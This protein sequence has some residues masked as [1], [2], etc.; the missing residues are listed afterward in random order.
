MNKIVDNRIQVLKQPSQ[1]EHPEKEGQCL[2]FSLELAAASSL[3]VSFSAL[4]QDT[5]TDNSSR[6]VY[7]RAEDL[8]CG[9]H[10]HADQ[11]RTDTLKNRLDRSSRCPGV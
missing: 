11:T 3:Y 10:Y 1:D 2:E 8:R 5:A 4:E 9:V 6:S 7:E